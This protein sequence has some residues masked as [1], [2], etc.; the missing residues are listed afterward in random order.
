MV[1]NTW[2]AGGC[3]R[4]VSVGRG[5]CLKLEGRFS[6]GCGGG[7]PGVMQTWVLLQG[8]G[9]EGKE[10][11]TRVRIDMR[12]TQSLESLGHLSFLS[13]KVALFLAFL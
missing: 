3:P 8:V 9:L 4:L 13:Q 11:V 1:G 12:G 10:R 7:S 6:Q 2:E 5:P